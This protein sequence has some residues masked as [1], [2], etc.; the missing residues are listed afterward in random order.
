MEEKRYLWDE[1]EILS[2]KLPDHV[3]ECFTNGISELSIEIRT[4][5]HILSMLGSSKH[6]YLEFLGDSLNL[7]LIEPLQR[8]EMEGLVSNIKGMFKFCHDV[9]QEACY[10]LVDHEDR[11]RNHLMYGKLFI[12]LYFD[13]PITSEK[14]DI[15]FMAVN[16][17][18]NGSTSTSDTNEL[19]SLASY[20]ITAGKKAMAMADFTLA[21]RLFNHAIT[22]RERCKDRWENESHYDASLEL[23][24]LA[25]RC[26]LA[27][28]DVHC[29]EALADQV[30]SHSR[31]FDDQLN[32]HCIIIE[33]LA[34]TTKI[35]ESL[36]RG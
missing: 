31:S 21:C 19:Y 16:Q 3:A 27:T 13:T 28:G 30:M 22:F 6:K 36:Q 15:L 35:K 2:M 24:E 23:H 12:S 18:N 25:A 11:C 33:S 9:I 26:R 29:I 7:K 10:N 17:I 34:Y 4:S 5:L 1:G 8:A 20:N 32:M 14:D